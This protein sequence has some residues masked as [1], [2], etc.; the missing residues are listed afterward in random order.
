M[1]EDC[2]FS[3]NQGRCLYFS[4]AYTIIDQNNFGKSAYCEALCHIGGLIFI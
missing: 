2:L 4:E 1:I 3:E